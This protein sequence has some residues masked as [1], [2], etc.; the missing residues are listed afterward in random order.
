M[1]FPIQETH[2]LGG[3]QDICRQ[4]DME[5]MAI[6]SAFDEKSVLKSSY[7]TIIEG[8]SMRRNQIAQVTRASLV[9]ALKIRCMRTF[10]V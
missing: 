5:R 7:A 4:L 8:L 3:L 9:L 1:V 6:S 2:I 10:E